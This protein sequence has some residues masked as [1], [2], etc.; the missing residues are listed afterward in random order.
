MSL[1]EHLAAKLLLDDLF[2]LFA[3]DHRV[4]QQR[5]NADHNQDA[6]G[7]EADRGL[8]DLNHTFSH[9]PTVGKRGVHGQSTYGL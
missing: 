5:P 7:A 3:F 1:Q 8:R 4:D 2:F 6:F 9:L